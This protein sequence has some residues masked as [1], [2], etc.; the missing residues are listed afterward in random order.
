MSQT[1][2]KSLYHSTYSVNWAF[3][4]PNFCSSNHT[5]SC[6]NND[7][8]NFIL[9][10]AVIFVQALLSKNV[11]KNVKTNTAIAKNKLIPTQGSTSDINFSL[12]DVCP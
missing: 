10:V 9:K 2:K 5:A 8:I 4:I 11:W 6:L 12:P 7:S 3:K 1:L